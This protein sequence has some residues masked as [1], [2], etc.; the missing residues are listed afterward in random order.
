MILTFLL[1]ALAGAA[2]PLVEPHAVRG[3]TVA[4]G[5]RNLP[6]PSGQAVAGYALSLAGAALLLALASDGASP[7]ALCLGGLVGAFH[8]EIRRAVTDRMG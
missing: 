1:G 7:L 6:G 2:G 4:L 5:P 3:L 8:R